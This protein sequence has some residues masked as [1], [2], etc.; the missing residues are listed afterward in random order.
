MNPALAYTTIHF[1]PELPP[2]KQQFN[3]L[4]EDKSNVLPGHVIKIYLRC[5]FWH[6]DNHDDDTVNGSNVKSSVNT[7]LIIYDL[8]KYI[9]QKNIFN[10]KKV[11][12]IIVQ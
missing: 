6:D 12:M 9:H 5:K 7:L 4:D 11:K 10:C 1:M 2:E 8:M 3:I